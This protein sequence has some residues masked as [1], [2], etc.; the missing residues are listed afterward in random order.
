MLAE[1]SKNQILMVMRSCLKSSQPSGKAWEMT[2]QK[3]FLII[4]NHLS[5]SMDPLEGYGFSQPFWFV[6]VQLI[7][8]RNSQSPQN[9]TEV[10]MYSSPNRHKAAREYEIVLHKPIYGSQNSGKGVSA[11]GK[12]LMHRDQQ[13]QSDPWAQPHRTHHT[14]GKQTL[15]WNLNTRS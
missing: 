5:L 15:S 14:P 3:V 6:L 12:W 10:R 7:F 9:P 2:H 11:A 1:E 4:S 13:L 8:W